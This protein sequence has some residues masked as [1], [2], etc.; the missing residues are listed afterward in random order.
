MIKIT[1]IKARNTKL[2]LYTPYSAGSTG[3]GVGFRRHF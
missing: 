2:T 3:E 1:T